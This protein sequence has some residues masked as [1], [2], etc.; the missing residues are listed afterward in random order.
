M[1]SLPTFL[2]REVFVR[3]SGWGAPLSNDFGQGAQVIK[4]VFVVV[5]FLPGAAF[6]LAKFVSFNGWGAPRFNC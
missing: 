1:G 6:Q 5:G 4:A 2:D 3:L